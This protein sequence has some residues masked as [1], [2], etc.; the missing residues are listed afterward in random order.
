MFPQTVSTWSVPN[1]STLVPAFEVSNILQLMELGEID[2]E[3]IL[4]RQADSETSRLDFGST[5]YYWKEMLECVASVHRYGIVHSDLKPA[6]F[7]LVGGCLKL[8]DFGIAG[9]IQE[10]TVNV[11]RENQ[12]GTPNYMAPEALLDSN[13]TYC[14]PKS[15][16]KLVKLGKPSDI[17]SLG[18]IL[19]LMVYR[20]QPFGHVQGAMR[21]AIAITNP[22]H[23]I[24]YPTTSTNGEE[25]PEACRKTLKTCLT[26]DQDLRPTTDTLLNQSNR[27]L[28]PDQTDDLKV[29]L[30]LQSLAVLVQHTVKH[31]EA[32]GFPTNGERGTS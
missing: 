29:E 15:G 2:L 17:W 32:L 19:Y 7:L 24:P 20:T 5:R 11:H 16:S 25:I 12:V 3:T 30:T 4:K 14:L 18:C 22:H 10:N 9:T 6:N 1:S 27:F 13:V 8:I 21:K 31:C 26:W 23:L 28:Y